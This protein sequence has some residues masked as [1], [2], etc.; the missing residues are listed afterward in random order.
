MLPMRFSACKVNINPKE[1]MEHEKTSETIDF[2]RFFES[3]KSR[4]TLAE[5]YER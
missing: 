4:L 1:M 3:S 5:L 2:P